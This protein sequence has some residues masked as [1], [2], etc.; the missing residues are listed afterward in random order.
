MS[1]PSNKPSME[2]IK[3]SDQNPTNDDSSNVSSGS[4]E[5]LIIILLIVIIAAIAI[6]LWMKFK[7]SDSPAVEGEDEGEELKEGEDMN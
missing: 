6:F 3:F 5:V 4:M 2:T 7:K 1:T